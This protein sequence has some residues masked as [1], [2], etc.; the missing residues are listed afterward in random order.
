MQQPPPPPPP[1]KGTPSKGSA[2]AAGIAILVSPGSKGGAAAADGAVAAG[3]ASVTSAASGTAANGDGSNKDLAALNQE[4]VSLK[5]Q[6]ALLMAKVEEQQKAA[7]Q[8]AVQAFRQVRLNAEKQFKWL[9]D[10][11]GAG[12]GAG[13]AGH[14]ATAS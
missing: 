4:V 6:N 11:Q 12:G 7:A 10:M 5:Q 3:D 14:Q 2:R 8:E 1:G 13:T 9:F